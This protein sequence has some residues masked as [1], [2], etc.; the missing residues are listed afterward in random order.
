SEWQ[1]INA[2][3][4]NRTLATP[5]TRVISVGAVRPM[6]RS[7]LFLNYPHVY[8][9][10]RQHLMRI[11]QVYREDDDRRVT[12]FVVASTAGGSGAGMVVDIL[13]ARTHAPVGSI[14][15]L[16]DVGHGVARR[17]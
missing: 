9:H 13:K 16:P 4:L 2:E 10:L 7:A 1:W 12:V 5:G 17:R 15:C 3:K 14:A 6:G 11:H 8:E